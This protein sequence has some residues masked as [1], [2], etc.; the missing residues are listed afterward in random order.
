MQFDEAV[1]I[2]IWLAALSSPLWVPVAFWLYGMLQGKFSLRLLSAFMTCEC[3]ALA[4][5][6]RLIQVVQGW[7]D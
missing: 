6:A 4:L 5:V 2:T 7:D 3:V 1:A